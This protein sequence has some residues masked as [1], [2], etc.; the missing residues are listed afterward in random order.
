MDQSLRILLL[1]DNPDD[2]SMIQELAERSNTFP[3][4]WSPV[5]Y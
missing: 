2:V 1:E 5:P 3:I 4:A